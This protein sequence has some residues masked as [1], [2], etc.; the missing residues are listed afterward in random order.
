MSSTGVKR[1]EEGKQKQVR[2]IHGT[3]HAR[4]LSVPGF[5]HERLGCPLK[6]RDVPF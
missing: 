3:K 6:T 4:A 1:G 5:D 2:I